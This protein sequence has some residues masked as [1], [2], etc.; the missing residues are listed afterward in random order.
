LNNDT[1]LHPGWLEPMLA[2][3]DEARTPGVVGNVQWKQGTR[4]IDHAGV[5]F[6][7]DGRPLHVA[8]GQTEIPPGE[9]RRWPAV[10]AACCLVERDLF[11]R[12]GGFEPAFRNGYEDVDFCLRAGEAG[13]RHYV[14]HRSCIEHHVSASPGRMAAEELNRALFLQ[15]WREKLQ[16]WAARLPGSPL[17][18]HLYRR[19]EALRYL[20]KHVHRPWRYNGGRLA[21]ALGALF[22]RRP[23]L[24]SAD[25]DERSFFVQP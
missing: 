24:A 22:R 12:L 18:T 6:L 15:R 3:H 14:A 21:R 23:A 25:D 4:I 19:S 17:D 1:E 9:Y 2:L 7:T 11:L 13:Y 10:T 20:R 5:R 16:A 8:R